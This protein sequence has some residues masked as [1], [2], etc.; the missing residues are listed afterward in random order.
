[1]T[2]RPSDILIFAAGFGTRMA[3]LTDAMPK[4]MIPV[5]GRPLIDHALG[6]AQEAGL[7]THVN[8]HYRADQLQ[9]HLPPSVTCHVEQ[10]AILDT[11]GGLKSALPQMAGEAVFTLNSDAIWAGPNPLN[12]LAAGWRPSMSALLLLVPIPQ[13]VGYTRDGDF[14]QSETG[15]IRFQK[16]GQV[17]TGAQIMR[18]DVVLDHPGDV[19]S[20]LAMWD[21]LIVGGGAYG[22]TY[23]GRWADVGTPEAIP[24]AEAML[25]D[26]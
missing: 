22:I 13:T 16:G 4:P 24:L 7:T 3:P 8:A 12:I 21:A 6:L 5:A 10:P 2:E 1:M 20:M 23:P 14:A 19:F 11:G 25:R 18:R 9:S 17:Y 15:R 26:V